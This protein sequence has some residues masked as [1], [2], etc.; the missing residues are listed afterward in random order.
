MTYVAPTVEDREAL[1]RVMRGALGTVFVST[2]TLERVHRALVEEGFVRPGSITDAKRL[3]CGCELH[4]EIHHELPDSP[5]EV[6]P[7]FFCPKHAPI[8]D[9]QVEAAAEQFGECNSVAICKHRNFDPMRCALEAARA[10]S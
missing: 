1:L 3:E 7:L 2:E 10:V 6:V 4:E 9:A 8:T 5:V